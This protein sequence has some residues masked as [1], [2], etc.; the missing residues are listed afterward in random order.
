MADI[1]ETTPEKEV[2]KKEYILLKNVGSTK[3][4]QPKKKAK[5]KVKLTE[6]QA[7]I[8]KHLKLI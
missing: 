3:T 6:E 4:G 5:S 7:K 2:A 8:Y 1:E